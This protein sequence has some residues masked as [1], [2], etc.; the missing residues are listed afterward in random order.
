LRFA[1]EKVGIKVL[2]CPPEFRHSNYYA[3]V[4]AIVPE[5]STKSE[6]RGIFVTHAFENFRHLIVIDTKT[7][8]YVTTLVSQSKFYMEFFHVYI[9]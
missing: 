7:Y 8:R 4:C 3:S 6:G 1:L 9:K 5:L 2:I